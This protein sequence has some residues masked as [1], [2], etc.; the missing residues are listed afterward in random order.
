MEE[1]KLICI[2]CPL[3]CPMTVTL[4]DVGEV[5]KVTGFT[6][7]KGDIYARK[8]VVNPTRTVTSTVSVSGAKNGERTVS[9]KTKTDVP[10]A[11]IFDV[12]RDIRN[13]T[14]KAPIYIGDVVKANVGGTGVDMVATKEVL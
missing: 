9:C 12:M 1:R 6:C 11:K 10:K 2:G 14:V 7:R 8:E 4:N 13:V 3:G 5:E